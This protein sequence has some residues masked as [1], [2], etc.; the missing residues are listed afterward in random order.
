MK[1]AVFLIVLVCLAIFT[2]FVIQHRKSTR[3]TMIQTV[4]QSNLDTAVEK[5]QAN[6]AIGIL[7]NAK[8]GKIIAKYETSSENA[9]FNKNFEFGLL[10]SVFNTVI[11]WE[12]GISADRNILL[13]PKNDEQMKLTTDLPESAQSKFFDKIH[14]NDI[15]TVDSNTTTQ[16]DLPKEWTKSE[17]GKA[18]IG[19]GIK[20]TPIHL[21]YGLNAVVNDG[22]YVNSQKHSSERVISS[23]TSSKIRDIMREIIQITIPNS[24]IKNI[25]IKTASINF[26]KETI[27]TALFVTFPIENPEYSMLV[28]LDNPHGNENTNGLKTAAWNV[29]PLTGQILTQIMPIL[30][31]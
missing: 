13:E 25:G 3:L 8:T 15:L 23:E 20:I 17:R 4:L 10:T 5:Y 9:I 26:D 24:P 29:V 21:I 16:P 2:V 22:L 14:F 18:G 6:N 28:I 30:E 1:K 7:I 11:A 31:K 12:N 27:T 19:Y